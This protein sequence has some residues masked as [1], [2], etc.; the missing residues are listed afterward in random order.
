MWGRPVRSLKTLLLVRHAKS[1]WKHADLDD[2]DRPLNKRGAR[3]APEMGR[4]LLE[5]SLVPDLIVSSP[6]V[7][8]LMTASAIAREV[9][10]TGDV[11]IEE[12]LYGAAPQD[13]LDIVAAFDDRFQTAMVVGH[14]PTM[15]QLAN[16]FSETP[17]ENVPTCGMLFIETTTWSS[18]DAAR[19]LDFDYPRKP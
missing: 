16:S 9:S 17:I 14:N 6:A 8:A 3:D 13:V 10:D 1:S 2:I 5:R 15:T 4:R 12:G 11:V 18:V 19:L 7:R